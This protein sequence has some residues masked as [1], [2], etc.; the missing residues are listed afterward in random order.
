MDSLHSLE[1]LIYLCY[2]CHGAFDERIPAWAFLPTPLTPFLT[3]ELTFHA[4]R[5]AAAASGVVLPRPP[6]EPNPT[7]LVYARYQ[8]RRGHVFT[9]VFRKKPTRTWAGNPV[10]AIIRSA[11]VLMGVQRLDPVRRC[12]IP[13]EV[14][15]TLQKLL[16]LYATPPPKV[17]HALGAAGT[18][19][20]EEQDSLGE[21]ESDDGDDSKAEE[22]EDDNE[23]PESP[24]KR[25]TTRTTDVRSASQC[26]HQHQ[27]QHHKHLLTPPLSQKIRR[28]VRPRK[29]DADEG[30]EEWVFGPLMTAGRI[31]D[32]YRCTRDAA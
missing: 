13:D 11:S 24:P 20:E 1:N 2:G 7:P 4:A 16:W 28:S 8:I 23:A 19:V 6:P 22:E 30:A 10:A 26:Q 15:E 25:R 27:H 31:V 9:Q 17:V 3:A 21:E 14:A 29:E 18:A 12:G 5:S 32:W